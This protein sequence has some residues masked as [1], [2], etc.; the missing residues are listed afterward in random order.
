MKHVDLVGTRRYFFA[1]SGAILLLSVVLL[2][3]LGLRPGIEFTSGTTTLIAFDQGVVQERLREVYTELGHAEAQIQSTGPNEF[4]IRTA[5]LEVPEGSFTEVAPEATSEGAAVGP[6]PLP[7]LGTL[8]VGAEGATGEVELFEATA[9]DVCTFGEVAA[10]E[11]AGTVLTVHEAFGDC[12]PDPVYRVT[13][14]DGGLGLIGMSDTHDFTLAGEASPAVPTESPVTENAGERTEIEQRLFE[15]FGNFEVRE[16]A[17]VSAVVS[18]V[19]VR[20]A[21][22]A[23]VVASLFIMGYVAFAFSGVPRPFRYAASAIAALVHDVVVVLGAFALF[24]AVFGIEINLMFITGLLTV[25]GFSVHDS[26]VVFDR[27]RENVRSAPTASLA[28]NVNSALLQTMAR[29][30][31]TSITVLITV[32]AMLALG[33]STIQEFLLVILVGVIAGTYSSIGI[34]AQMLVAWEEG[35][36][37]RLRGR[38][39]SS[40]EQAA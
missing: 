4:L 39:G 37:A 11:A 27:I 15:E 21:A 9:G 33:G 22:A 28:E 14:T 23:V 36:F 34:A 7:V 40:T 13:T 20:N 31:N 2:A 8:A 17:S 10:T 26:I 35:D 6:N 30:M 5:E 3:F 1:G 24:G 12:G 29:S 25:I 32:A 38:R 19:A 18:S 16:F